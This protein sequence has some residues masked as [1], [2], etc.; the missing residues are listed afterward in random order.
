MCKKHVSWR[1]GSKTTARERMQKMTPEKKALWRM[2]HYAYIDSKALF[3]TDKDEKSLFKQ[4]DIRAACS[5]MGIE[6]NEELRVVPR[7]PTQPLGPENITLVSNRD[8]AMLAKIWRHGRDREM[9]QRA[10]ERLAE[11]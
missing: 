7:V 4:A 5:E 2:W 1:R 10:L 3:C 6:P 11:A 9:Y 8:R